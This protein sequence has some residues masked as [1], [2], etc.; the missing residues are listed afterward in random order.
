MG[1]EELVVTALWCG[2]AA[3]M[4]RQAFAPSTSCSSGR[5]PTDQS[6]SSQTT[7]V[8]GASLQRGLTRARQAGKQ[9]STALH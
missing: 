6:T 4:I 2:A 1:L 7:A 3:Y 9:F 8:L 5:N